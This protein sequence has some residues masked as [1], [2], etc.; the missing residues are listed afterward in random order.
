VDVDGSCFH[1]SRR[2]EFHGAKIHNLADI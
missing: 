2:L 1:N